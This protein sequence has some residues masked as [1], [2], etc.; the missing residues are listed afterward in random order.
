MPH[1]I[2]RG[3]GARAGEATVESASG[4]MTTALAQRKKYD[5]RD[6]DWLHARSQS[7]ADIEKRRAELAQSL[8]VARR[9]MWT[10]ALGSGFLCYYLINTMSRAMALL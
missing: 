3:D 5:L 1:K 9:V 4:G 6:V 10:V 7:A 8:R 2:V